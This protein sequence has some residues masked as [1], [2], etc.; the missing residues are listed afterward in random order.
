MKLKILIVLFLILVAIPLVSSRSF[1]EMENRYIV[2]GAAVDFDFDKSVC[3]VT[4]E[5]VN[6]EESSTGSVVS[7]HFTGSG[8]SMFDA[9]R[10]IIKLSGKKLFWAHTKVLIIN[11]NLAAHGIYSILDW[12]NRDQ[13]VRDDIL[14]VISR[15]STAK[16]ILECKSSKTSI[17]SNLISEM[18]ESYKAIPKYP[19]IDL[20]EFS[21]DLSTPGI[22]P[23]A[24]AIKI[25]EA[26]GDKILQ[27]DGTAIFLKDS[28]IDFLD[29]YES[30]DLLIIRNMLN[31]GLLYLDKSNTDLNTDLAMEIFGNTTKIKP[32]V[33]NESVIVE[34]IVKPKLGLAEVETQLDFSNLDFIEMLSKTCNRYLEKHI[35]GTIRTVQEKYKSDIFGFGKKINISHP[36]YWK[37]VKQDWNNTFCDQEFLVKVEAEISVTGVVSKPLVKE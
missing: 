11:K 21:H 12:I 35:T 10:N 3:I 25:V 6:V 22:E 33:E 32:N 9:V 20:W 7:K 28:M 27:I 29:D 19:K 18:V 17:P 5:V 4:V 14:I 23:I 24:P 31:G 1:S 37:D 15:E 2:L 36:S 8:K 13:E 16:E 30:M 34:I 26:D